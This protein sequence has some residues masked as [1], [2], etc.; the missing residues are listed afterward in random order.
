MSG[1]YLGDKK[2]GLEH[3]N[4][5]VAPCEE[6]FWQ[7]DRVSYIVFWTN[8]A[9]QFKILINPEDGGPSFGADID[10]YAKDTEVGTWS[11][12]EG[13]DFFGFKTQNNPA[14]GYIE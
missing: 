9:N 5:S 11:P 6:V 3:G 12:G 7:D 8:E 13:S 2:Y 10:E 1:T 4:F 14:T